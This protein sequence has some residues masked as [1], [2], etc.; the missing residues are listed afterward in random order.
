[1]DVKPLWKHQREAVDRASPLPGFALFMEAG[2]GK[3]RT[4]IEIIRAKCNRQGRMLRTLIFCPNV[5]ISNWVSEWTIFSKLTKKQVI[6]L[7]GSGVK[8]LADFNRLRDS[9]HI[10]ISNYE[11]LLMPNLFQAFKDW[12]PEVVTLDES[13]KIKDIKSKRTK[14]SCELTAHRPHVY[15]LTGSPILNTP[16]DI[17]SQFKALDGGE[18]FGK[19]FFAFR[20]KYFRDRNEG[21][22]TARYFP[23]WQVRNIP[24]DGFDAIK[25]INEKIYRIGIRAEKK[26]CLDL[27][28]EVSTTIKVGMSSEQTRLYEGMKKDCIAFYNSK[29]CT[30]TMALTKALRL[31]QISSGFVSVEDKESGE[32]SCNLEI[33]LKETPKLQAL[34]ELLADLAEQK[35]KVLVWAVWKE[36]YRQIAE[37]LTKMKIGFVEVHGGVA[38]NAKQEAI[39]RFQTDPGVSVFLGN[40]GAAGIGINLQVS[41][42]SIFYSRTFS[43]EHYLQARA[44]NHRGGSKEAGHTSITHIDLVVENT[45][46]ELVVEKLS[47]KLAMS[48]EVLK[49][50]VRRL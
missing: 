8:R 17:F 6:G 42:T 32:E 27:P 9:A 2:T 36:N 22:P 40:P 47:G 3:T 39:L 50:V 5:V 13:H 26:D 41:D 12:V 25:D 38:A 33:S 1:M 10:F 7:T 11:A 45:I 19:N 16:M 24:Q 29:A 31:L 46:D 30:A 28:P 18:S 20:A 49:D 34:R 15:I 35:K 23:N 43:L 14:L 37:L 4:T 21:M 44:R 48:D